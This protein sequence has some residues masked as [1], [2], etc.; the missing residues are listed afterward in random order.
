[1]HIPSEISDW[2]RGN[3]GLPDPP[4]ILAAR[5]SR[6]DVLDYLLQQIQDLSIVDQYGNNAL[7]AACFSGSAECIQLLV[8]AD[9]DIDYQ[10]PSGASALIYASSSGKFAV[11]EQLLQAGANP[12]LTTQDDFSALDLAASRL[13]LQLLRNAVKVLR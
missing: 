3:D 13:C 10:N 12:L 6:A 7:W 4:L 9:I 2:L 11:V 5:Q 1:M 8:Q